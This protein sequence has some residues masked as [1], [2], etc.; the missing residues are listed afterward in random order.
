MSKKAEQVE[1]DSANLSSDEREL[2]TD[3]TVREALRPP[4]FWL[5]MFV[6]LSCSVSTVSLATHLLPK[7]TDIGMSL[8]SSGI[9]V[10]TSTVM[11]IPSQLTSGYLADRIP[12]PPMIF[13]LLCLQATSLV[14]IALAGSVSASGSFFKLGIKAMLPGFNEQIKN[15]DK[16]ITKKSFNI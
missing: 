8:A 16:L 1:Y 11:A 15:H 9:V 12:K 3:F 5:L 4:A 7:L 2:E 13:V 6:Q 14:V 10:L